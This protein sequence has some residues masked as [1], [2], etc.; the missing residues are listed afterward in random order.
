M[1]SDLTIVYLTANKMPKHWM[2]FQLSHLRKAGGGSP[3]ISISREPIDLGQNI[4]EDEKYGYWNIYRQLLAGAKVAKTDY[5]AMAED[6]VLY[7]PQ[8]FHSFR[9]PDDAV[10]YNR[11][12]WSLFAWDP[13]YCLRQRISNCTLIAPRKLLIEAIE[14]RMEKHPDGDDLPRTKVG[15]IGR[16]KVERWLGVTHRKCMEWWSTTPVIQVNHPQGIDPAQQEQHKKHG[17][18]KAH[19]IPYWGKAVDIVARYNGVNNAKST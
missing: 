12:R 14:E 11:A 19:D 4:V 8:H 7:P 9:P 6:D 18:L 17:Q 1:S 16:R 10:S 3:F 15:E 2:D 5:V 13:V